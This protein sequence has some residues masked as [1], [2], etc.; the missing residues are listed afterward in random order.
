M[1]WSKPSVII[2]VCN[3]PECVVI[4][5]D[6]VVSVT[7]FILT[8]YFLSITL[9]SNRWFSFLWIRML[10]TER[11]SSWSS[12]TATRFELV[13]HIWPLCQFESLNC[14]ASLWLLSTFDMWIYLSTFCWN[15]KTFGFSD[16]VSSNV[17]KGISS[18]SHIRSVSGVHTLNMCLWILEHETC[19]IITV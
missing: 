8:P 18:L 3:M 13:M 7:F 15:H 6:Q 1:R 10:S 16:F 12:S 5:E 2:T 11:L 19:Q 14:S 9:W 4:M 17:D